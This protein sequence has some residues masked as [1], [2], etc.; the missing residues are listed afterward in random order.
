MQ[1]IMVNKGLGAAGYALIALPSA[2]LISIYLLATIAIGGRFD[3]PSSC[4]LDPVW[5]YPAVRG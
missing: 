2:L 3:A 4:R 5:Q 1:A